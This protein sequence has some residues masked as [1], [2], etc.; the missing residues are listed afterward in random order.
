MALNDVDLT[1]TSRNTN[2]I[3]LTYSRAILLVKPSIPKFRQPPLMIII[4]LNPLMCA[5]NSSVLLQY[6]DV[7]IS[8][9]TASMAESLVHSSGELMYSLSILVVVAL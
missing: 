5:C 2:K 1:W 6:Q 8:W 4:R 7:K 9:F 3:L